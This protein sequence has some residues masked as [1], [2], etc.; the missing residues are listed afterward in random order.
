[1]EPRAWRRG[2]ELDNTSTYSGWRALLGG[3]RSE[4]GGSEVGGSVR[5]PISDLRSYL[6]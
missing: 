1:M 6:L 3:R 4:V 2:A 5:P